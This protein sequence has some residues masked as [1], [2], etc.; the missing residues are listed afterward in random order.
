MKIEQP[1]AYNAT[2]YDIQIIIK[3]HGISLEDNKLAGQR[4]KH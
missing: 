1:K 4:R 2:K 3:C